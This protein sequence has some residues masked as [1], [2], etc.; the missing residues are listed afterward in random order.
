ME[1]IK[2]SQFVVTVGLPPGE[3]VDWPN[4]FNFYFRVDDHADPMQS[5][6]YLYGTVADTATNVPLP[7]SWSLTNPAI[8]ITPEPLSVDDWSGT[9]L[10]S[11]RNENYAIDTKMWIRPDIL[12]GRAFPVGLRVSTNK[13]Q[14]GTATAYVSP[15]PVRLRAVSAA[16]K[17]SRI[18][19][20][21][22]PIRRMFIPPI[23]SRS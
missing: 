19:A 21:M 12:K 18:T 13:P 1:E 23:I 20:T 8:T 14:S 5:A 22:N 4:G 15:Y 6:I 2:S 11:E 7:Q 10:Y 17:I 9:A 3:Q 16:V